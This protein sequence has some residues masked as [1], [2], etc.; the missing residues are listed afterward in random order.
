M[1][2]SLPAKPPAR[3]KA[4]AKPAE[5]IDA[6][7]EDNDDGWVEL[8]F[9]G[10][11]LKVRPPTQQALAAFSLGTS[12]HVPAESRNNLTGLFVRNHLSPDSYE[13]VFSRLLDPDDSSYSI[14]SI[15]E[16]MR[17]VVEQS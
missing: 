14:D 3:A 9:H 5:V 10:D 2:E 1:S 15:G 13:Q 8:E 17:L 4:K 12:K 16:L 11:T 6:E 7:I